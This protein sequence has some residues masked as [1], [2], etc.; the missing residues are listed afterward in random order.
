MQQKKLETQ[1]P[2]RAALSI[3]NMRRETAAEEGAGTH[4]KKAD[5]YLIKSGEATLTTDGQLTDPKPAGGAEGD[6]TAA[7]SAT[8]NRAR[9]EPAT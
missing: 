8:E 1:P 9:S 5:P 6:G 7:A 4:G 2:P 3:F